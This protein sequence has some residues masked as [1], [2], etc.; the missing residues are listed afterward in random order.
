MMP[1]LRWLG[2]LLPVLAAET[3]AYLWMNPKL[4]PEKAILEFSFPSDDPSWTSRAELYDEVQ[5][6][7]RCSNGWISD[8]ADDSGA[9]SRVSFFKWDATETYNTLEAFKHLPEQCMGAVGMELEMINPT[10]AI[11]TPHGKLIFDSTQFRPQGSGAPIHIFK[12]VWVS[13]FE[14][15]SLR[16]NALMG[17]N[18]HQLRQLRVAAALSRFQPPHTRIIM[19]GVSGMPTEALAWREF[20]EVIR[21]HLLWTPAPSSP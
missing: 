13:G 17:K 11:E 2:W 18:G 7:L 12:C 4:A 5:P 6:S 15:S 8:F 10:R 1:S 3:G 14:N 9:R 20:Q 16:D 21:P 19:G